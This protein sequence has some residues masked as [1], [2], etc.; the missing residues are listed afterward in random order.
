MNKEQVMNIQTLTDEQ[1]KRLESYFQMQ[2]NLH[3]PLE[4]NSNSESEVIKFADNLIKNYTKRKAY[5]AKKA[6]KDNAIKQRNK[7]IIETA[8]KALNYISKDEVIEAIEK[9]YKTKHNQEIEQQIRELQA[10]LMQ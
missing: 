1:K 2:S 9:A 7:E 5:A 6:A 8:E 10:K 4:I 3:R